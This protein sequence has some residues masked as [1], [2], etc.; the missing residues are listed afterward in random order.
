MTSVP[1]VSVVVASEFVPAASPATVTAPV[2]ETLRS[3]V[4]AM[5]AAAP[6]ASVSFALFASVSDPGVMKAEFASATLSVPLSETEAVVASPFCVSAAPFVR[7][8]VVPAASVS[9][10]KVEFPLPEIVSEAASPASGALSPARTIVSASTVPLIVPAAP[11]L[12]VSVPAATDEPAPSETFV[13]KVT[14]PA[15]EAA[16]TV[17]L[18]PALNSVVSKVMSAPAVNPRD[19]IVPAPPE[20]VML[21]VVAVI[22]PFSEEIASLRATSPFAVTSLSV[23]ETVSLA[24]RSPA[25]TSTVPFS[26]T[27]APLRATLP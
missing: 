6:F 3:S 5:F 15:P 21:P 19:L 2:V 14:F 12:T 26:E 13:S 18:P 24:V 23:S 16:L 7:D 11:A 9:V 27:T 10:A 22:A 20:T 8:S 25:S 17:T 1:A 4:P